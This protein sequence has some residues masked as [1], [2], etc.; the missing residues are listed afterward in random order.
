[1]ASIKRSVWGMVGCVCGDVSVALCTIARALACLDYKCSH[2][3]WIWPGLCDVMVWGAS[4]AM[5]GGRVK[6]EAACLNVSV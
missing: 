5:G 2:C 6:R 4:G 1:M 3:V